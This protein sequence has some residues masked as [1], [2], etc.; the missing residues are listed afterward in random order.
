GT[1]REAP[2]RTLF[3][4]NA[5]SP[6][7][8]TAGIRAGQPQSAYLL[9][10]LRNPPEPERLEPH[11]ARSRPQRESHRLQSPACRGAGLASRPDRRREKPDERTGNGMGIAKFGATP[12]RKFIARGIK[13]S[14]E[15]SGRSRSARTNAKRANRGGG[16]SYRGAPSHGL[17]NRREPVAV[18]R[19]A[20]A[21]RRGAPPPGRSIAKTGSRR[22]PAPRV[23]HS[24]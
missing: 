3:Q 6:Q 18:A 1:P 8:S 11:G 15:A 5:A 19:R 16:S 12:G 10:R 13:C 2:G 4:R 20:E 21:G 17:R 23:L 14:Y 9:A 24:H 7:H 22:D